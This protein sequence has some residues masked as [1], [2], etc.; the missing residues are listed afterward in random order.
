[1]DESCEKNDITI[2][3]PGLMVDEGTQV[4]AEMDLSS[5]T[6]I[7]TYI[8]TRE[9]E[10]ISTSAELTN[11]VIQESAVRAGPEECWVV[12]TMVYY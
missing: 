12:S 6:Q 7:S 1:M 9:I 4:V 10:K 8:S 11:T 5:F 3:T 2:S